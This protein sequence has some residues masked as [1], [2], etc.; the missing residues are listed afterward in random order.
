M[1]DKPQLIPGKKMQDLLSLVSQEEKMDKEVLQL[2]SQFSEKF[3]NDLINRA[4]QLAKHKGRTLVAEED[5]KFVLE[6]EF[7]YLFGS[8]VF[9]ETPHK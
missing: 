7:G 3:I 2:L 5:I 1:D 8:P 4:S 6:T 9:I